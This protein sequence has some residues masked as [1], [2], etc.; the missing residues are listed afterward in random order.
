MDDYIG[1]NDYLTASAVKYGPKTAIKD[2]TGELTYCRFKEKVNALAGFLDKIGICKGDKIAIYLD[3]S[4]DFILSI[5]SIFKVLGIFIPLPYDD[6]KKRIKTIIDNCQPKLIITKREKSV[7]QLVDPS[8]T[9]FIIYTDDDSGPGKGETGNIEENKEGVTCYRLQDCIVDS[10]DFPHEKSDPNSIAYII[11]TSGTTGEPKGV[12]IRHESIVNYNNETTRIFCFDHT[13]RVLCAS[14][15]HF[16]GSFGSIFCTIK[17]G[18]TIIILNRKRFLP[19]IFLEKLISDKITHW[20][21]TP[22]LFKVLTEELIK[23]ELTT[24]LKLKTVGLGGERCPGSFIKQF[25]EA[26]PHTRIF[27][28]YGPTETTVVVCSHEITGENIHNNSNVPIGKPQK[29]VTF[30][31]FNPADQLIRPGETGELYIGG[32]QVMEKY[33]NDPQ[34][35]GKVLIKNKV[36][37]EV[38]FKTGDLVTMDREGSYIFLDRVDNMINKYGNRIY[39]SEIENTIA[40]LECVKDNACL[41]IRP[42]DTDIHQIAAFIVL[43]KDMQE[44]ELRKILKAKLPAAMIPHAILFIDA[45]PYMSNGKVDRE[46]LKR[47]YPSSKKTNRID[48]GSN[49]HFQYLSDL[50]DNLVPCGDVQLDENVNIV[51]ALGFDSM[52]LLRLVMDIENLYHIR[53]TREEIDLQ[54]F[55]TIGSITELLKQKGILP[56]KDRKN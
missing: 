42:T 29:N 44:A 55:V 5:F 26:L 8:H 45:I 27:N 9:P 22:S 19:R 41:G 13:T 17:V 43:I 54:N 47:L 21:G 25:K 35:T 53:F 12:A 31:A 49:H 20:S 2:D 18:G 40:E 46:G 52:M 48:T 56:E 6:P 50:I 4:T 3:N 34:L 36:P 14:P 37:G 28:R 11:Y 30:F 39:L 16:D 7:L 10:R 32:I 1:I 38:L 24:P 15:F 51:D 33:W 23:I